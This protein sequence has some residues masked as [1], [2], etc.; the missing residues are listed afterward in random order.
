MSLAPQT[1]EMVPEEQH[2]QDLGLLSGNSIDLFL[3]EIERWLFGGACIILENLRWDFRSKPIE[4][5]HVT[6]L[7]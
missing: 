4:Y 5:Q 1:Q 3:V 6:F 7:S 2:C